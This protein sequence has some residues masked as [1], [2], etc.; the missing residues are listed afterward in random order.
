[1]R[2][3]HPALERRHQGQRGQRGQRGQGS[4]SGSGS[5]SFLGPLPQNPGGPNKAAHGVREMPPSKAHLVPGVLQNHKVSLFAD[6]ALPHPPATDESQSEE[7]EEE[8]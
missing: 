5:C 3:A 8:P 1:M 6:R 7:E 2:T 4:V